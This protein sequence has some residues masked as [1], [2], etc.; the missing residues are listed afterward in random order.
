MIE[1]TGNIRVDRPAR[2]DWE[3]EGWAAIEAATRAVINQLTQDQN[4]PDGEL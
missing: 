4:N 1:Y 3:S 2:R